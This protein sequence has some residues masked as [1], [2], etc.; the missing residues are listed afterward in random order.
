MFYDEWLQ[1]NYSSNSQ[2]KDVSGK[3]SR[4]IN[5]PSAEGFLAAVRTS[6]VDS[7][8]PRICINQLLTVVPVLTPVAECTHQCL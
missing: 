8:P 4:A 3:L 5:N 7:L 6:V 1:Y 2:H